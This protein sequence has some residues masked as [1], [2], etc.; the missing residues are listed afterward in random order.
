M[1]FSYTW[2]GKHFAEPLPAPEELADYITF[3]SSEIEEVST[4]EN[5]DVMLD[6]KVLPDRSAWLMSHRGLAREVGA[7]LDRPLK[8]DPFLRTPLPV[9]ASERITIVRTS[10]TCDYYGA[11]LIEGVSVKP[12]P[13]WL[14]EALATIGQR[15]INNIVD[16]T[17][18]VMFEL[19]QPLHAFAADKLETNGDGYRIGIRQ[20][21][22]G[23]KITALTGETY[24]L[25]AEDALIVDA[26]SDTPIGIA[27]I[28]GGIK[29]AVD[30]TTTSLIVESAHFDRVAVRK[31][32][33]RL[34]LP[35]DA[36]K[37]FE[38]GIPAQ[39]APIALAHVVAL[40]V[41]IAGGECVAVSTSG[42]A[43][44]NRAPVSTTLSKINSVLGVTLTVDTVTALINRLGFALSW[45][46]E[47]VTVVPPFERDD[48]VIAED[49]I[50][51]IGRVYGFEHVVSIKPEQ[52][53]VSEYNVRHYYAE[54]IRQALVG[55]GFSEVYTSSFRA[56]D[57]VKLEN[58][59]ATDKGYLRSTLTSNLSEARD[60]NVPYR[61]LLGLP[62]IQLFEIGTV[63]GVNAEEF[64]VALA[65]QTGTQYKAKVD[66]LRI[67]AAL[68]AITEALGTTPTLLSRENGLVEFSLDAILPTLPI[69]TSY[70]QVPNRQPVRYQSFSPYPAIS[71]DIALW[72]DEATTNEAVVTVLNEAAGDLRVRTTPFDEFHKEGRKSLAFRLVFQAPDRTLTDAEA[73]T[74]MAAVYEA[75]QT[76]GWSVR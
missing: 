11:A 14:R 75:V 39:V 47:V 72:V 18:Y 73:E 26:T 9:V 33:K 3:H 74:A 37:R 43:L 16:A 19:G 58:A 30:A 54:K 12:S 55:L 76:K 67:D 20:A 40:I 24:E 6:V 69:P 68:R 52:R 63:F 50:D 42:E 25:T 48:I 8:D 22:S 61:D 13:D 71:R 10:P 66:D 49:L 45:V 35:T 4:L 34:R 56:E 38:N 65:V 62:A 29:A 17:N 5:G 21:H 23:E 57:T 46:G 31:S 60:R 28:K 2:L 1:K 36:A 64:R 7:I 51:D 15:S 27:G 59:L 53:P 41:E 32:A 70:D 44:N